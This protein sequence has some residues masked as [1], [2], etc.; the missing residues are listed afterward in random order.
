MKKILNCI[1]ILGQV[2]YVYEKFLKNLNIG[3]IY[4]IYFLEIFCVYSFVV[5]FCYFKCSKKK[6]E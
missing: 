3:I 6:K 2:N 5:K 4:N 1:V